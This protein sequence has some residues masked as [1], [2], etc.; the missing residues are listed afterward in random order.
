MAIVADDSGD[1]IKTVQDVLK[2][3]GNDEL[4]FGLLISLIKVNQVSNKD[5][6]D[7]LLHLVSASHTDV[8]CADICT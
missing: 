1:E 4:K 6:V 8:V 7:T 2:S 5:V 3:E